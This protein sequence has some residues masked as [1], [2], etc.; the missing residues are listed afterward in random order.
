MM[1]AHVSG[2]VARWVGRHCSVTSSS[3]STSCF[4]TFTPLRD[5]STSGVDSE[6]LEEFFD[7]H[8]AKPGTP[9]TPRQSIATTR[10]ESLSLYRDVLRFSKFFTWPDSNGVPFR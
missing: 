1:A 7:K 4:R 10:K 6:E 2:Q 5:L 8:L 9:G 3:S